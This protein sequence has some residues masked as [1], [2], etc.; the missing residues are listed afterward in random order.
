MG[1]EKVREIAQ[2]VGITPAQ[3]EQ[4]LTELVKAGIVQYSPGFTFEEEFATAKQTI[5]RR[6]IYV[7]AREAREKSHTF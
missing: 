7:A 3:V 5:L 2:R 4:V 6:D 1:N